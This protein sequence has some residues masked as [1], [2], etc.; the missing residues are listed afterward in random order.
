MIAKPQ[1][2]RCQARSR[3][4]RIGSSD[5]HGAVDETYTAVAH[6]SVAL[7][8]M[9]HG[10]RQNLDTRQ[11]RIERCRKGVAA[12]RDRRADHHDPV[13]ERIFIGLTIQDIARA[14]CANGAGRAIE[15]QRKR[16]S[17]ISARRHIANGDFVFSQSRIACMATETV[18][19][20]NDGMI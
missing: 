10:G 5:G 11:Y 15:A 17:A 13:S 16:I 1:T 20:G 6:Q 4:N 9:R 18:R 2:P 3:T 8:E 14:D 19:S 7:H 12:A